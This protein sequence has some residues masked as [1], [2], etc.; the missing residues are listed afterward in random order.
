MKSP[1][2]HTGTTA[3]DRWLRIPPASEGLVEV[4]ARVAGNSRD[5]ESLTRPLLEALAKL[6]KLESTYLMVFDWSR[7]QQEVRFAYNARGVTVSEGM[8]VAIAQGLS[9]QAL[10]GVTRSLQSVSP[11]R[12]RRAPLT[13]TDPRTHA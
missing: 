7:S 12:A 2:P 4:V 13:L 10:P 9:P 8:R 1:E 6:A 5:L 3:G 11:R